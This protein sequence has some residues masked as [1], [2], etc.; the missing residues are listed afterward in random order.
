MPKTRK[1]DRTAA[2]Y[3]EVIQCGE[4]TVRVA[5]YEPREDQVTGVTF[6]IGYRDPATF[7]KIFFE[8]TEDN[9]K[10]IQV[11]V[12]KALT[13]AKGKPAIESAEAVGVKPTRK[14]QPT[15]PKPKTTPATATQ[16]TGRRNI[17]QQA[18]S[19]Q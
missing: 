4:R 12:K 3:R 8:V 16:L 9:W 10:E 19:E 15:V 14:R 6:G 18:S 13:V 2:L 5:A 17:G 11:A 7:A 1:T